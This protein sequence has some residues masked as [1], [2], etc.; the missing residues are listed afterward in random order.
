MKVLFL[1]SLVFICLWSGVSP[2]Q[3]GEPKQN[4]VFNKEGEV[5]YSLPKYQGP[6]LRQNLTVV[7]ELTFVDGQM[8]MGRRHE[9]NPQ[10]ICRN[11]QE[12]DPMS[13]LRP[14]VAMC[15]NQGLDERGGVKW[16]CTASDERERTKENVVLGWHNIKIVCEGYESDDSVDDVL[17]GSCAIEYDLT[18][19][20]PP[21]P[22]SSST[23][24]V[25]SVPCR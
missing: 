23:F 21:S 18:V 4:V 19:F 14:R 11:C 9:P 22:P 16:K 2:T 24:R 8:T 20:R 5:S 7:S 15:T 6:G 25:P 3:Q 17:A 10:M 13:D 12:D 1:F